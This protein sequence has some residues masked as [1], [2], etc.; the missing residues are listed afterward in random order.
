MLD[1]VELADAN[2][3]A[4]SDDDYGPKDIPFGKP[5]AEYEAYLPM[6]ASIVEGLS[7]SYFDKWY[8]DGTK[9]VPLGDDFW[10]QTMPSNN[11][12]L[13]ASVRPM[14]YRV[15]LELDGGYLSGGTGAET[16]RV[17]NGAAPEIAPVSKDGYVLLGWYT[18]PSLSAQS[19][20]N[21]NTRL[22]PDTPGMNTDYYGTDLW[23][24]VWQLDHNDPGRT[25]R[26]DDGEH[27]DVRGILYLY[28]KWRKVLDA[29]GVG[30]EYVD[31][32]GSVLSTDGA[33]YQ[34]HA[35][36]FA[37]AAPAAPEGQEFKYWI[38]MDGSG[39]G[40]AETNEHVFAGDLF[41]IRAD[42]AKES[43][44]APNKTYTVRLMAE[45]GPPGT[46]ATTSITYDGNF[47][48]S[49][50][51]VVDGLQIN[52]DYTVA[53]NPFTRPGYRFL[54]WSTAAD[55]SGTSY[56]P[57]AAVALDILAP[58]G[59]VLYAIWQETTAV[60]TYTAVG[61]DGSGSVSPESETIPAITGTAAGSTA[62]VND[63]FRFLGWFDN[64]ACTGEPLT[65]NETY[66]PVRSGDA[67]TDAAYYARFEYDTTTL[68]V[69][70]ATGHHA[71]FTVTGKGYAGANALRVGIPA[72]ESVTV[73]N[74]YVGETYTVSEE[75][76]WS[77][78]FTAQECGSGSLS[79]GVNVCSVPAAQPVRTLWLSGCDADRKSKPALTI[80][81]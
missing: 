58:A 75:G 18:D 28:A 25:Q 74:V 51:V 68:T 53:D 13:Y 8:Q 22:Y 59:N 52:A 63:G 45:F 77:W 5:I 9:T 50:P 17:N 33:L 64:A 60:I 80:E 16:F 49:V 20:F 4:H 11:V 62:T 41:E 43:G 14:R 57:G 7:G 32:S 55:D 81:Q 38:V 19:A 48:C 47:E 66:V 34:D 54:H 79:A 40:Y 15:V 78:R 31:G 10:E 70:N 73:A 46:G 23:H 27:E 61:P 65:T 24:T 30:V 72:G 29:D 1:G 3:N 12:T 37:A 76:A 36:A 35:N 2:G 67:W 56:A 42:Y 21:V 69:T 44:E 26:D 71:I 39:E 6:D